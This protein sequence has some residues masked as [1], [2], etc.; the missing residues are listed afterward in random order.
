MTTIPPLPPHARMVCLL[1]DESEYAAL[2]GL[3]PLALLYDASAW[4]SIHAQAAHM[5]IRSADALLAAAMTAE[6]A[7]P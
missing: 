6:G 2:I 7:Q 1:M 3:L 4:R 5:G